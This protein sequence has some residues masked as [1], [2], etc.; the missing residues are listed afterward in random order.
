MLVRLWL[1]IDLCELAIHHKMAKP[2]GVYLYLKMHTSGKC[3][4]HSNVFSRLKTD[5]GIKSNRTLHKYLLSLQE[6]NWIGF[7]PL[8]GYYFIRSYKKLIDAQ[9][10]KCLAC[11][12]EFSDLKDIQTLLTGILLCDNVRRQKF[13]WEKHKKKGSA[14]TNKGKIAN[15]LGFSSDPPKYYGLSNKALGILLGCK[16]TRACVLKQKAESAGYIKTVNRFKKIK[17]LAKKDYRIRE[18]IY[19]QFPGLR[20][21][22]H[23][24]RKKE[25]KKW[26]LYLLQQTQDEIK[27]KMVFATIRK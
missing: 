11:K 7:N 16:Q 24:K 19:E 23:F 5:L 3:H 12:V 26:V 8:S 22:L 27:P 25:N 4:Q 6:K 21:R 14:A 20:G 1:P 13:F 17:V 2:L 15:Q 9:Q 10:K 18:E